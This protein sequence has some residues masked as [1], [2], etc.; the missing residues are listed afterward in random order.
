[1]IF[2]PGF[3]VTPQSGKL[4]ETFFRISGIKAPISVTVYE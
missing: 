1:M 4:S 3:P 2:E